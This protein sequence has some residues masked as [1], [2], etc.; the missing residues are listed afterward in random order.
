MQIA[1]LIPRFDRCINFFQIRHNAMHVI[2]HRCAVPF[3]VNNYMAWVD[4][5]RKWIIDGHW[6]HGAASYC[7]SSAYNIGNKKHTVRSL[8]QPSVIG[9]RYYIRATLTSGA[10]PTHAHRI[11]ADKP[12]SLF[13]VP[14]GMKLHPRSVAFLK[15]EMRF[16]DYID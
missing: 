16:I 14:C 5:H 13:E 10:A 1:I 8:L 4:L 7:S 9:P 2:V 11:Q 15:D 6:V 3:D 12:G